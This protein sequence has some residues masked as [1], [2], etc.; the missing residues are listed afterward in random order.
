[1]SEQQS[2]RQVRQQRRPRR[3][4]CIRSST[5]RVWTS[6]WTRSTRSWKPLPTTTCVRSCRRR[7]VSPC[8]AGADHRHRTRRSVGRL[9][10]D[11]GRGTGASARPGVVGTRWWAAGLGAGVLAEPD[12]DS[13]RLVIVAVPPDAIAAVVAEALDAYPHA[14]VSDVGRWKSAI[15]SWRW[16]VWTPPGTSVAPDGGFPTVRAADGGRRPVRRSHLGGDA[17][18]RVQPGR[19]RHGRGT[20]VHLRGTVLRC[21]PTSMTRPVAQVSHLPQLMSFR[22]T[23]GHLRD[24]PA[25]QSATGGPRCS[26]TVTR[27]ARSDPVLWAAGDSANREAIRRELEGVRRDL[28]ELL[29]TLDDPDAVQAFIA[30]GRAGAHALPGNTASQPK[31]FA[32]VV[33]E[34]PDAPGALARLFTDIGETGLNV[35]DMSIEHD[36]ARQVGYLCGGRGAGEGLPRFATAML[37][38]GWTLA[39][40]GGLRCLWWWRSTARAGRASRAR[41][42]GRPGA[43]IGLPRTGS[44]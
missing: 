39:S 23:A 36:Q 11:Q 32:S 16:R 42:G 30:R 41:R 8:R 21:P 20:G 2:E 19:R 35:E 4:S 9:G 22:W 34:I 44:M 37:D 18:R 33:I 1:M 15:S 5:T 28:D 12:A 25:S 31:D 26:E 27:I 3:P 17:E 40:L 38:H 43:R 13:V 7:P 10:P 29:A 24:V 14:V 6:C